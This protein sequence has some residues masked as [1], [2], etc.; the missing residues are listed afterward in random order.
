MN[1]TELLSE[2]GRRLGISLAL[3][4]AGSCR[5]RFDKDTVEFEQAGKALY[6]MADLGTASGREDAF[7]RLLEANCLGAESGGACLGLDASRQEFTLHL[8]LHGDMRYED[9]EEALTRFIRAL[10]YWKEW[11]ALPPSLNAEGAGGTQTPDSSATSFAPG[12]IRV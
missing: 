4:E 6:V 8:I 10:R 12:M 5:V 3:S 9:F 7:G 1:E 11:L 2:L